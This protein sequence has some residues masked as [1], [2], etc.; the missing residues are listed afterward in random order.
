MREPRKCAA[1]APSL[2]VN[3][4]KHLL[5]LLLRPNYRP[6][7]TDFPDADYLEFGWGGSRLL[8]GQAGSV[9]DFESSIVAETS[10]R[11]QDGR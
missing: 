1:L 5:P 10:D 8:P 4:M 11:A 9:G 6:E 7:V 2:A 3:G